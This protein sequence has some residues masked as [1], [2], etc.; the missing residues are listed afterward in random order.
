MFARVTCLFG[1]PRLHGLQCANWSDRGSACCWL[2]ARW[3]LFSWP[4]DCSGE[5]KKKKN[6]FHGI[7][8]C[9][10]K[11][12]PNL[13]DLFSVSC[14]F[15]SAQQHQRG[16]VGVIQV[17]TYFGL[18]VRRVYR[19]GVM[20]EVKDEHKKTEF[21][22]M[23]VHILTHQMEGF[24]NFFWIHFTCSCGKEPIERVWKGEAHS[25]EKGD[26]ANPLSATFKVDQSHF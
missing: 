5:E 14:L 6:L 10:R 18:I 23:L 12:A 4:A 7:Y 20:E 2:E 8:S 24:L 3:D 1:T 25:K 22:A 9:A 11:A 26:W 17:A 15:V 16:L 19:D 21:T 13:R